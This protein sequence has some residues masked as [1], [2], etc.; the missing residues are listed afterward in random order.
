MQTVIIIGIKNTFE[1]YT[2]QKCSQ[3]TLRL[4]TLTRNSTPMNIL[5]EKSRPF[6]ERFKR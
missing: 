1:H 4:F 3:D 2:K 5:W 6:Y